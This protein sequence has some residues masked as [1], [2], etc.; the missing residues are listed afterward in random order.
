PTISMTITLATVYAPIGFQGGLTG[1]LFREFAFTLSG[2]VVISGVVALTLSPMMSSQ[3]LHSNKE[4]HGFEKW[5]NLLF[6]KIKN[7]YKA[8]LIETLASR[9]LTITVG[10]IIGVLWIPFFLF[11]GKEPAPNEDQGVVFGIVQAPPNASLDQTTFFSNQFYERFSKFPECD[12][13]FQ[14]INP[15]GGFSG[16]V[17]KPWSQRHRTAQ[18]ISQAAMGTFSDLAGIQFIAVTPPPL[19]GGSDFPVE[20]ILSS[21]DEPRHLLDYSQQLVAKAFQSGKFMFADCDL[22]FDIPQTEI[23]LDRDKVASMGLTLQGV[24]EDLGSML[25]GNYVNRFSIQ[26]RSYKVIPQIKRS[27]RL[28]PEQIQNLYVGGPQG[29]LVPLSTFATLKNTVEPRQLNRFQQLNSVKIYGPPMPGTTLDDALKFLET[30]ARKIVPPDYTI[31]YSGQSRQLRKESASIIQTFGLAIILIYLVLAAQF[32]SFRDPLIILLGSVPLALTGALVFVFFGVN[33]STINIY[34]Q[35]GLITLVGLISKNGILIVEF[36][37]KLQEEGYSKLDAVREAAST[38][39]RPILMTTAA[40]VFGHLPLV[41]V[42]GAGAAARNNIG[43]VL[44]T[45]MT[46]GTIF[47]LFIVPS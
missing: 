9:F 29:K 15:T 3:L 16:M 17:L 26:G 39:L 24:S 2:A 43:I 45:G 14:I 33:H 44:V 6:D 20:F 23:I 31:D 10:L 38:R 36:A 11:S 47:T 30:E 28:N 35:V 21:T 27:Q 1:S 19:P 46:I 12:I 5:L 40:T 42:S 32:E 41:F 37:N 22:K 8:I 18:E 13:T 25:G 34:T 4:I 7:L